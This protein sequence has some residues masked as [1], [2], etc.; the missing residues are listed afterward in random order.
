MLEQKFKLADGN[1][2]PVQ[3]FGLY[4]VTEQAELDRAIQAAWE[5]G[6]RLFD[7][8]QMY[9]NEAMVGAAISQ[10][11]LQRTELFL[12]TKIAEANQGYD[13]TLRSFEQSL[14]DLQVDYVDLLLVHWPLHTHF[15]ET[16]QAFERLKEEGLARSIGVSNYS[17]THLQYLAT[18]A[19][20]MP[21]VDQI[22]VHPLLNQADMINF[23]REQGIVTQAWAPLGRGRNLDH[24]VLQL[25]AQA[26]GK[27]T[28]QVIL[29]WH[30]QNGISMIPK[31][32]NPARIKEN[33]SIYDFELTTAQMEQINELNS[34]IRI[35]QEPELV[36]ERGAQYPH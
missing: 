16:W 36:Y 11:Q 15:F 8:A 6:Y 34:F 21:V 33:A 20:M 13:Q 14:R 2:M 29:R 25:I 30:L 26:V 5:N 17:M 19:N 24:P 7:T 28:A 10:N 12:T 23:N 3:G 4:K 32:V 9:G 18:K 27:T 31:S 22:E 35:S 1:T